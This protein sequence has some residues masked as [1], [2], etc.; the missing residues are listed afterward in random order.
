MKFFRKT[1]YTKMLFLAMVLESIL[2]FIV[3]L[4]FYI[5]GVLNSKD[6]L[7][8]IDN[9]FQEA[10]KYRFEFSKSRE[11]DKID[12]FKKKITL[13]E[14]QINTAKDKQ[15][16]AEISQIKDLY[17]QEFQEYVQKTK[18][19]GLDETQGI[20][21][22]FRN[23]VHSIEKVIEKQ[24]SPQLM[25]YL[26]QARRSEKD[27][28]M[29]RSDKYIK[30]VEAA[31]GSLNSEVRSSNLGAEQKQEII[32]L[33]NNYLA[34]FKQI[35]TIFKE[36][37]AIENDLEQ[38]ETKIKI[39][40]ETLVK[41]QSE[42]ADL[43]QHIVWVIIGSAVFAGFIVSL[44]IA[45]RISRPIKELNAI[46]TELST[47]NYD[48][49][50]SIYG[51]D[52]IGNLAETFRI[53]LANM[54]QS[55]NI[56]TKQKDELRASNL[57]LEA[58]VDERTAQLEEAL[59]GVRIEMEQK[60]ELSQ[61]LIIAQENLAVAFQREKELNDMKTQFV[62]MVS[63]EYR[64]PLT[65]IL[66]STYILEKCFQDNNKE[67]FDKQLYRVQESVKTMTNLLEDVLILGKSDT[68]RL[69]TR[70]TDVDLVDFIRK[71]VD[72]AK[73]VNNNKHKLNFQTVHK[74]LVI[75]S[76][77]I[78]INHFTNNLIYNA[79]KYSDEGTDIDIKLE[80]HIDKISI[81]V[82]DKGKG[83]DEQELDT[84]FEPFV[85]GKDSE[86]I[87][88]TGLGLTIAKRMIETLNGSIKVFTKLGFG[89]TFQVVLPKV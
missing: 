38:S 63:H 84:L 66:S 17:F 11:I 22:E 68:G 30:K 79:S 45:K 32:Q 33:S 62:S 54:Q 13:I 2:G 69:E 36:L 40:S 27:F 88:G 73:Y 31:I 8:V 12:E 64:S 71:I 48:L 34:S 80:E 81:F 49:D 41:E 58:R 52:E 10:T 28:I 23:R 25:V 86:N 19:R 72:N 53:M 5:I 24:N 29:R 3:I 55:H 75:N 61:E 7:R 57:E 1:L 67:F 65:V 4:F 6:E 83:I 50:V 39:F 87:G 37:S 46:A 21:G 35:T 9:L 51:D 42:L 59:I 14:L 26:L 18:I 76:D 60:E 78:L 82:T 77:P 15:S 85:R 43:M 44:R 89:T 47:G 74:S 16:L 56:I 70:K 20:E